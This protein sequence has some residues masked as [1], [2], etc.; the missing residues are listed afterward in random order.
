MPFAAWPVTA[1]VCCASVPF[2]G[3]KTSASGAEAVPEAVVIV[4]LASVGVA[5]GMVTV[6]IPVSV[7]RS[8]S[9]I[10]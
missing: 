7:S 5:A 9:E 8:L 6:M 10:T 1:S 4:P 2:P 3:V